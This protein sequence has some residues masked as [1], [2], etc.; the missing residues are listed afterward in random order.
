MELRLAMGF[1][2][3]AFWQDVMDVVVMV[4]IVVVSHRLE[5]TNRA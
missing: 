1:V 5:S 2:G 4:V 3:G